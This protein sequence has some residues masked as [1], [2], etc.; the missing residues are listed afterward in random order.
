[1]TQKTHKLALGQKFGDLI[2]R[3]RL[4]YNGK[5]ASNM[6]LRWSCECLACG[7]TLTVPEYYMTRPHSPKTH[8]GCRNKSIQTYAKEEHG[9]WNM[10]H[11]RCEDPRHEA[12]KHYGGRGIKICPEWHKDAPDGLGFERFLSFMGARPSPSHSIDRVDNDQ[13]YQPFYGGKVQVRWA[14]AKEQR[15]N[16]RP[17]A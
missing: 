10:M 17:K 6:R 3:R 11:V 5:L 12:Y 9:I 13:G 2:L 4:P 16:Q 8:C 1:M 15:A 7:T 14:T